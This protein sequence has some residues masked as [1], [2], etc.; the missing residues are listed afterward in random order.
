MIALP[1]FIFFLYTEFLS[2]SSYISVYVA[3]ILSTL[4]NISFSNYQFFSLNLDFKNLIT[5]S[6]LI[7]I[8]VF[9]VNI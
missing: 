9:S 5:Y 7:H 3:T 6:G 2:Y 8:P 1:S 4:L